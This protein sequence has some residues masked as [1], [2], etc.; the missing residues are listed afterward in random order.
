[1][2]DQ[3]V[4]YLTGTPQAQPRP[5]AVRGRITSA[6][7]LSSAGKAWRTAVE[8]ACADAIPEDIPDWMNNAICVDMVFWF[9]TN[10]TGRHGLGHTSK[11]DKDNL[12]KMMLDCAER[13]GLLQKGDQRVS[14]GFTHKIWGPA[15]G[16]VMRLRPWS[17]PPLPGDDDDLGAI[18][19]GPGWN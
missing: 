15:P 10:D 16:V 2:T 1:M 14:G 17:P 9:G 7:A 18:I 8:L 19:E 4:V 5:R 11:P 3:I 12:E 6:G 13:A